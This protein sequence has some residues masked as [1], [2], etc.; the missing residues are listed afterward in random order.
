M[1][2]MK[3]TNKVEMRKW[4]WTIWV[5]VVLGFIV[6]ALPISETIKG[7]L[8]VILYLTFLFIYFK[9]VRKKKP[10]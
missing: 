8:A 7:A 3:E 4:P 6:F 2:R 5:I 10:S 1:E 9:Y